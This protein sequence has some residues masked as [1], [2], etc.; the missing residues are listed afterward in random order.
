MT[1]AELNVFWSLRMT[2]YEFPAIALLNRFK[3]PANIKNWKAGG[4]NP[5]S[6]RFRLNILISKFIPAIFLVFRT[7]PTQFPRNPVAIFQ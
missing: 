7:E 4:F 3:K 2:G 1:L 6:R 5:I